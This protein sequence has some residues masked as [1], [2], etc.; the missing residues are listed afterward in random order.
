MKIIVEPS[1]KFNAEALRRAPRRREQPERALQ[2]SLV[3]HLAWRAQPG[4]WWTHFPAGGRRSRIAGAILKG[5]G[6]K[7]G[8]PDI[9][10]LSQG[11]LFG[12][13][14]KAGDRGRLSPA[15]TATHAEMRN[16]GAVIGTAGT[17]DEALDLLAE[18]G[19]LR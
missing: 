12:L 5:M 10:L 13:E 3:E 11:R 6:A 17:I 15:Q 14:L 16:A 1:S 4:T 8:V 2:L 18:W 19:V 7:P 9:L